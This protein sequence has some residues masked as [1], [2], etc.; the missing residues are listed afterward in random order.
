MGKNSYTF[1][2]TF[3]EL[4]AAKHIVRY[5]LHRSSLSYNLLD[6]FR[7][8][9]ATFGHVFRRDIEWWDETDL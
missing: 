3:Q 4:Q 2:E 9:L 1:H 8:D 5:T 7:E 6:R